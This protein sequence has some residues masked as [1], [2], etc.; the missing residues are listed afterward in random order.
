MT[1]TVQIASPV[2]DD[3]PLGFIVIN[4]SDFDADKHTLFGAEP[5]KAPTAAELRDTLTAKGIDFKPN[6]SKADLQAA[7]DAA[8][9]Q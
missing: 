1:P 5:T 9:A 4:E 3:N 7:L 2:S 8:P 6:A